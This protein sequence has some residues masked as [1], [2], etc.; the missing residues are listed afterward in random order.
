MSKQDVAAYLK[1]VGE[2][3]QREMDNVNYRASFFAQS[4]ISAMDRWKRGEKPTRADEQA[5]LFARY[6]ISGTPIDVS[7]I[8][9]SEAADPVQVQWPD[10]T[11]VEFPRIARDRNI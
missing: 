6:V 8:V 3:M 4:V 7:L 2:N 10:S 1:Q 9:D 11:V 5:L